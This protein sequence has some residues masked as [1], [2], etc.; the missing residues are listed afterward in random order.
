MKSRKF[1]ILLRLSLAAVSAAVTAGVPEYGRGYDVY[2]TSSSAVLSGKTVFL[3]WPAGANQLERYLVA[4]DVTDPATP[5]L[6]DKLALDGFPQD[7]ALAGDRAY[8]VN[9]RDLLIADI[10]DPA[11]LR[12]E[13]RLRI[14]DDPVRGPQGIALAEGMVWLACR[15]GGIKAVECR[16]DQAPRIAGGADVPAFVRGV[17]VVGNLLYAAGDTRGVF[18]FDV[19]ESATPRL[20]HHEPA[21]AGCIGR[22]AVH[23]GIAYLAAGNLLAATLSLAVPSQPQWL[24][25]TEDR[26][27]MSPFYGGFAHDLAVTTYDCTETGVSR[28]LAVVADGESGVIVADV[29]RP[30]APRFLGAVLIEGLGSA[31]VATGLALAGNMV[32]LIDQSFGLRIVDISRPERPLQIGNGLEL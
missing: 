24:G 30:E 6:L 25:A 21:P 28:T 32:Y 22:I 7:L 5:K 2:T 13:H 11:A 10:T 29:S 15:R 26:D 12:L 14:D 3:T 9:G 19:A 16:D 31:Y 1:L 20:R 23:D 17:T 4:I 18:A 27:V 8:V